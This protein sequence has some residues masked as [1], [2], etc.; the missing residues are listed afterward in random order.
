MNDFLQF[1]IKTTK[2]CLGACFN[3]GA[4]QTC[5]LHPLGIAR[6]VVVFCSKQLWRTDKKGKKRNQRCGLVKNTSINDD[7]SVINIDTY[8]KVAKMVDFYL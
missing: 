2:T 3:I 1:P 5:Y 7:Y 4:A 8:K 6:T